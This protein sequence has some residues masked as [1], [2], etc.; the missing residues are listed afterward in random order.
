MG[1]REAF[2]AADARAF[3]FAAL[4]AI[5]KASVAPSALRCS[6]PR[7]SSTRT[8]PSRPSGKRTSRIGM[9]RLSAPKGAERALV[10]REGFSVHVR[11]LSA[12]KARCSRRLPAGATLGELAEDPAIA[13]TLARQ[14]PHWARLTVIDGFARPC[15]P[16][17]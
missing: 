17:S 15:S 11:A 14:L 6:R 16:R 1:R 8:I 10:Y 5:P 3:D 9:E 7:P 12:K 2:H 4:A 13:P